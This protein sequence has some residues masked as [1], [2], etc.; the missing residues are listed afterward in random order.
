MKF[1]LRMPRKKDLK[2]FNWSS[3]GN[4]STYASGI[5]PISF[6]IGQIP[7][8]YTLII[9]YFNVGGLTGEYTIVDNLKFAKPS[10]AI[11]TLSNS[12]IRVYPN[13]ANSILNFTDETKDKLIKVRLISITGQ[14]LE[15]SVNNSSIDLSNLS[16]GIYTLEL[17]DIDHQIIK[18]EKLS[19]L[20]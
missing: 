3:S 1:I 8:Y 14:S 13:P 16:S 2:D 19:V 9:S 6:G 11:K 12:T 15:Y 10:A 20:N 18:R 5:I 17:I 4:N 7:K